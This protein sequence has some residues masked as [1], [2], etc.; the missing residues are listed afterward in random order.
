V[1]IAPP[2]RALGAQVT[3]ALLSVVAALVTVA[4]VFAFLRFPRFLGEDPDERVAAVTID[5]TTRM[6]TIRRELTEALHHAQRDAARHR[7]LGELAGATDLETVLRRTL[8]TAEAVT[9]ADGALLQAVGEQRRRIMANLGLSP[10]EARRLA[11][12]GPPDGH[13]PRSMALSYRYAPSEPAAGEPVQAGLAVALP[14]AREPFG[15]LIVFT[16]TAARTFTQDEMAELQELA[17]RAGPAIEAARI[18]HEARSLADI[19]DLTGLPG[20][21]SFRAALEQAVGDARR[22]GRPLALVLLN[23]DGFRG[24]NLRFGHEAGDAIL[25]RIAR[26]LRAAVREDDLVGRTG[27]DEFGL[28]LHGSGAPEA[29]RLYRRLEAAVASAG[30]PEIPALAFSAGIAELHAGES[31]E[32]LFQRADEALYRAQSGRSSLVTE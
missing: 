27:G 5:L 17:A 7:F 29:E 28:L 22:S 16:R 10:D 20:R 25:A 24:V 32:T 14:G 6:E 3:T 30:E 26:R 19:D 15:R 1:G 11:I 23:V 2:R 21:R 9:D 4:I 12:A 8:E 31:A 13:E 18:V